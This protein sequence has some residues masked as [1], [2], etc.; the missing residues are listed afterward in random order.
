MILKDR[1]QLMGFCRVL[2][3]N[4]NFDEQ[5][6]QEVLVCVTKLNANGYKLPFNLRLNFLKKT[7][8]YHVD[9]LSREKDKA[10]AVELSKQLVRLCGLWLPSTLGD[11]EIDDTNLAVADLWKAEV[12]RIEQEAALGVVS[13]SEADEQL[14][15]TA[16]AQA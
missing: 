9:S 4:K 13:R 5:D 12:D 7:L 16:K 10:K 15:E 14:A 3:A 8:E 11:K 6:Y 2:T 1:L